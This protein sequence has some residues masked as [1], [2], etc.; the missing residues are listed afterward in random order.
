[1]PTLYKQDFLLYCSAVKKHGDCAP[2]ASG[3]VWASIR[4]CRFV[5]TRHTLFSQG[6]EQGRFACPAPTHRYIVRAILES[7]LGVSQ[8]FAV[9]N[10]ENK[11]LDVD[12]L[13]C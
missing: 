12:L 2:L 10:A 11:V 7:V 4:Q 13:G 9:M 5:A 1:M 8:E 3:C 6:F